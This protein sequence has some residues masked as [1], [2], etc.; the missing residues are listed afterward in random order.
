MKTEE[1]NQ[2]DSEL[3]N[4]DNS[5]ALE[6]NYYN[7][8]QN[9]SKPK[10]KLTKKQFILNI[11]AIVLAVLIISTL[12]IYFTLFHI[13]KNY[14][15]VSSFDNLHEPIQIETTGGTV[16]YI[17]NL[18]ATIEFKASYSI[19]G[20]VADTYYYLPT[21][22]I[23][24]LSNFDISILWGKL[25]NHD[26]DECFKFKNTS[27]RR[28]DFYYTQRVLDEIGSDFRKYITNNHL[29]H[30]NDYVLKCLRNVK[31]GDY[32]NIE[33]YLVYVSFSIID[34]SKSGISYYPWNSSLS[35]YDSGDGGCE[36]IYVTNVSWLTLA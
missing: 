26:Y 3:T 7:N 5:A 20:R 32:I 34:E 8:N 10:R 14:K 27:Q 21:N 13:T 23:N 25:S 30:D 31:K 1:K 4:I 28:L 33:G 24:K 11:I 15:Y 17:D 6:Y 36:I 19:S 35:R 16:K 9:S 12:T 22:S 29:I 18:K 2:I